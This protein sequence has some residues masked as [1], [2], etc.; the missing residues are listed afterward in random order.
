MDFTGIKETCIYI[1]D[2]EQ[3]KAFYYEKLGLE[4]ISYVEEKHI[5]FRAGNSVLLC[6]N[7]EDSK[8]KDSPPPHFANGP[9]HFAFEVP[10]QDYQN[11]KEEIRL[12]GIEI[13]DEVTWK[14]GLESFYFKDFAGNVLEIVPEGVWD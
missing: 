1:K 10:Q 14:S 7:P 13:I 2:L 11:A 5:F 4:I 9:I 6:F 3:A 8:I 12:K